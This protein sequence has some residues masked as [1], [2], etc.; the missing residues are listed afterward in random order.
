M[1]QASYAT[2]TI[3]ADP[4][5]CEV[6][7]YVDG[8][9]AVGKCPCTVRLSPGRHAITLWDTTHLKEIEFTVTAKAGTG[10]SVRRQVH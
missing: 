7:V 10:F 1:T 9:A 8:G 2:A 4:S 5:S 3:Q 6:W